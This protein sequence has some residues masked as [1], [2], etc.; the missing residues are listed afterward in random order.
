MIEALEKVR[1]EL[2]DARYS[3]R[4]VA[5]GMLWNSMKERGRQGRR[6]HNPLEGPTAL[7][8]LH[9]VSEAA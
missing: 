6:V 1:T 5:L 4:W 8:P 2:A 7:N 3:P 9:C